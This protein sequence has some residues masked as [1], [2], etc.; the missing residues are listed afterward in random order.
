MPSSRACEQRCGPEGLSRP[1]KS[2]R[3][4]IEP[5]DLRRDEGDVR[6]R[7]ARLSRDNGRG[8]AR[9]V[10]RQE[11]LEVERADI[12]HRNREH[13]AN[14]DFGIGGQNGVE[15]FFVLRHQRVHVLQ[16]GD[17]VPQ[18]FHGAD[19]RTC[20]QLGAAAL[21]PVGRLRVQHPDIE[22]HVLEAALGKHVI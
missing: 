3:Q 20:T 13:D 7:V 12:A 14:P 22:G 8:F 18:A 11:R 5:L 17:P 9:Y 6:L 15:R 16:G 1:M 4:R 10:G 2:R 21:A 19:Q